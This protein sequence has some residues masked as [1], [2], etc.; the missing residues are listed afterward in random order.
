MGKFKINIKP[1]SVN[2][3]WQGRRFKSKAYKEFEE[4]ALWI[5]SS[6]TI[7]K[8]SG[9][10]EMDYEFHLKPTQFSHCDIGN[11]EK[12]LTDIIVKAGLIDDDRYIM[13]TTLSKYKSKDFFVNVSINKWKEK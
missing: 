7:E 11:F 3:A 8:V 6:I 10:V 9:L 4:E 12:P 1:L 13:R 5:L 2:A